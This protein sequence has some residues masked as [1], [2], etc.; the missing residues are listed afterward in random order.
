[1]QNN[2]AKRP[3]GR[4]IIALA[5]AY[6]IAV[7][8]LLASFGAARAAAEAA[9]VA[10]GIICHTEAAQ[11]SPAH[12][13]GNSK[14]CAASCCIGCV[15]IMAAVPPPPAEFVPAAQTVSQAVEP[16]EIVILAGGPAAKSHQSRA[17]PQTA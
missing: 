12:D 3:L 5:A 17:P 7:S 6:A 9:G 4:R 8:S 11:L 1:V 16:F 15:T 14:T 2:F 13:D 10:G